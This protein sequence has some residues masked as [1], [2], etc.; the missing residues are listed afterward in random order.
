MSEFA[1]LPTTSGIP[2]SEKKTG[3]RVLAIRKATQENPT[4]KSKSRSR[5]DDLKNVSTLYQQNPATGMNAIEQA[6]GLQKL[7]EQ[8]EKDQAEKGLT[9]GGRKRRTRKRTMRRK[10]KR[11][12]KKSSK[13]RRRRSH[14]RRH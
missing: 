7:K 11:R 2:T 6:K 5:M 8:Y 9:R 13:R 3:S 4:F 14:R 10:S 12:V 1:T